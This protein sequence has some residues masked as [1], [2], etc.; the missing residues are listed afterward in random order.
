[1]TQYPRTTNLGFIKKRGCLKRINKKRV[2]EQTFFTINKGDKVSA[3][4]GTVA[5]GLMTQAVSRTIT[6]TIQPGQATRAAIIERID[7]VGLLA[8]VA[9]MKFQLKDTKMHIGDHKVTLSHSSEYTYGLNF[10][11]LTR[12]YSGDSHEDLAMIKTAIHT[13]A[14]WHALNDESCEE[15]RQFMNHVVRG[16]EAIRIT[17]REKSPTT[18]DALKYYI[19]KIQK[20]QIQASKHPPELNEVTARLKAL[21]TEKEIAILNTHLNK[22]QELQGITPI[23][24]KMLCE[25]EIMA[26]KARLDGKFTEAKRIFI[27]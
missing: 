26:Y 2:S 20:Y 9:L 16:I 14:C 19:S 12:T 24:T 8:M 11:G 7:P 18:R 27:S 13:V 6:S 10:R 15:V 17:Y 23:S 5:T 21:W 4:A 25:V 22:M 1:V 3:L